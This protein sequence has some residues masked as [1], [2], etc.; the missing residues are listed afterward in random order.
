MVTNHLL[1]G[2]ILQVDFP[3]TL[4]LVRVISLNPNTPPKT[5]MSKTKWEIHLNQPLIFSGDIR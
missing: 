2:M 5:N 4:D 3:G 1:N